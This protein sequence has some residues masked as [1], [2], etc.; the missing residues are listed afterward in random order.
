MGSKFVGLILLVFGVTACSGGTEAKIET[1]DASAMTNP[2]AF[3]G[4]DLAQL[5]FF[6]T[7]LVLDAE[8]TFESLVRPGLT[9][10]QVA[11]DLRL[12]FADGPWRPDIRPTQSFGFSA[13]LDHRSY[14]IEIKLRDAEGNYPPRDADGDYALS[15]EYD[16][17][18][19]IQVRNKDVGPFQLFLTANSSLDSEPRFPSWVPPGLGAWHRVIVDTS[20][21]IWLESRPR[22]GSGGL[23][24]AT[25][26][27]A[28]S[29][30][31]LE[32]VGLAFWAWGTNSDQQAAFLFTCGIA[33]KNE[34]RCYVHSR[35]L[36]TVALPPLIDGRLTCRL[37][38]DPQLPRRFFI[39][40]LETPKWTLEL[41]GVVDFLG[42]DLD[43]CPDLA[44]SLHGGLPIPLK[45]RAIRARDADG[46]LADLVVT[47][48]GRLFVGNAE[49]SLTCPPCLHEPNNWSS[50]IY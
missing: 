45:G 1:I 17:D 23:I 38:P 11:G 49:T 9:V 3:S 32:S 7:G 37:D 18:S 46:N 27:E 50:I 31:P 12:P 16:G 15:F 19:I 43:A 42:D 35:S 20:G 41:L 44:E 36:L 14:H 24:A 48:D 5:G 28:I 25:T 33:H 10:V 6:N 2:T 8:T 22:A 39:V 47:L 29:V 21:A 26:G 4:D 40:S 34:G 30:A 13:K